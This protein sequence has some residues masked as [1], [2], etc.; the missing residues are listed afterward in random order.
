MV[1]DV[2]FLKEELKNEVTEKRYFHSLGVMKMCEKLA[3]MYKVDIKKAKLVGLMHDLAKDLPKEEKKKYIKENNIPFSQV[4]MA[5]IEIMHGKIA[6]DVCKKKY[7]FDEEMCTSI[8][9]HTTGMENM[10][11][12]EKV[13]F[14]ADKIDE[15]RN[16]P[17]AEE[18]REIAYSS[19]DNAIIKNID[20]AIKKNIEENKVIIE[21]SIK[22]RN[23]LLLNLGN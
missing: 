7:G 17:F 8:A 1:T 15:T 16:Y 6:A 3:N 4:E 10:T 19:L 12:L 11:T 5:N 20:E 2:E 23:Y 14:V 9:V 13:L 22:T 18:L 21:D